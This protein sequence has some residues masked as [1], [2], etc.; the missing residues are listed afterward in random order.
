METILS[1]QWWG[2]DGTDCTETDSPLVMCWKG[3]ALSDNDYDPDA[4]E[5]RG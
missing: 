3:E 1:E 5:G 2:G 4:V